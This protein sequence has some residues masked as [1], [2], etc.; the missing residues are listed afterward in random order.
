MKWQ[1]WEYFFSG[2]YKSRRILSLLWHQIQVFFKLREQQGLSKE[3]T[4]FFLNCNGW[5]T[6]TVSQINL[7][8]MYWVQKCR[9]Q[10]EE[11]VNKHQKHSRIRSEH[12]LFILYLSLSI[13][14]ML[15]WE[16]YIILYTL[17]L[18]DWS[19]TGSALYS[20]KYRHYL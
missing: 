4:C 17:L 7:Y 3:L 16:I 5:L 19:L 6:E 15:R 13:D 8:V 10:N 14:I 9:T 20:L 2:Q 11:H 1:E 12:A 18:W